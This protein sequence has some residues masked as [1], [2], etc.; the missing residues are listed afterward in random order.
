MKARHVMNGLLLLILFLVLGNPTALADGNETLGEPTI[1]IATGTRLLAAGTGLDA[2]PGTIRIDVPAP[3]KQAL[4]Y[5]EGQSSSPYPSVNTLVV[6]GV[7]ITGERIGMVDFLSGL[8]RAE[9]YRAD[10]TALGLV[11]QGHN[12]LS[13]SGLGFNQWNDGAGLFVIVDDI[14]SDPAGIQIRD[15]LDYAFVDFDPPLGITEPQTFNFQPIASGRT[16][17]LTL[18]VGGAASSSGRDRPNVIEVTVAGTTT[19][20]TDQLVSNEGRFWDTWTVPVQVPADASSLTV[21]IFSRDDHGTSNLPASL[22]WVAAGLTLPEPGITPG[23][24]G[25]ELDKQV[26][27]DGGATWLGS[28]APGEA[29][30]TANLG[31]SLLYRLVLR[32]TGDVDLH[33][34]TVD[35]AKLG[36]ANYIAGDLTAGEEKTLTSLEIPALS[37]PN[38]C[39]VE[40]TVQNTAQV[41]GQSAEDPSP[42]GQVS[43]SDTLSVVCAPPPP[44]PCVNPVN[45]VLYQNDF[46]TEAGPQWSRSDTDTAPNGQKFLGQFGNDTVRLT[47]SA[48]VCPQ[49]L[50]Q[51]SFDLYIIRSWDGNM[52]MQPGAERVIGPDVFDL[53]VDGGP[54]LFHATFTNWTQFGGVPFRQSYPGRHPGG[55]HPAFTGAAHVNTLGYE[56]GPFKQDS[57][58]RLQAQF[59]YPANPADLMEPIQLDFS[60]MGLQVLSDESWGI[61]NFELHITDTQTGLFFPLIFETKITSR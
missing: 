39:S 52:T 1:P 47:L 3:V 24:L 56:F 45:P 35:D 41:T 57:V 53:R 40:G 9:T 20:Y 61:D 5:W 48:P 43:N 11:V 54:E 28:G 44:P 33:D 37:V 29:P 60:G 17:E 34:V 14:D 55:D 23:Q 31:D 50:V 18:F 12:E 13:V 32:N 36:I 21:Q 19:K 2:Q 25:I 38:G 26:S 22:I 42:A 49:T 15:G 27:L 7:S 59:Y 58:Y 6:D 51:L 8:S 4:L 10:I 16:A 46:E 30:L